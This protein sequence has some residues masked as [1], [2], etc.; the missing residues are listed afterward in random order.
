ML[1]YQFFRQRQSQQAGSTGATACPFTLGS[2]SL[3]P[4]IVLHTKCFSG[5]FQKAF[6]EMYELTQV[7]GKWQQRVTLRMGWTAQLLLYNILMAINWSSSMW[8][9]TIISVGQAWRQLKETHLHMGQTRLLPVPLL[10]FSEVQMLI[11][12]ITDT[13]SLEDNR[14]FVLMKSE[15]LVS[16][17][18][19]F[20]ISLIIRL[21]NRGGW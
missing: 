12:S 20:V 4:L 11:G 18:E 21:T 14:S 15:N 10:E 13:V 1:K 2:Q 6:W 3:P 17:G 9:I 7:E 19:S 16:K 5:V 8:C